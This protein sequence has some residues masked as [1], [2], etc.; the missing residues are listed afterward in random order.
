MP[1]FPFILVRTSHAGTRKPRV[2]TRGRCRWMAAGDY[3][4]SR[5][6]SANQ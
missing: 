4:G 1:M 6:K 5:P 2:P 3:P